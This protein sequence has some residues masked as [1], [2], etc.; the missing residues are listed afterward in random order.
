MDDDLSAPATLNLSDC[1]KAFWLHRDELTVVTCG[2]PRVPSAMTT[3]PHSVTITLA[4]V[5]PP[6]GAGL[7]AVGTVLSSTIPLPPEVDR[8][9]PLTVSVDGASQTVDPPR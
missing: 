4:A 9:Q 7:A 5:R 3:T 6:S 1:P 8:S 2:E